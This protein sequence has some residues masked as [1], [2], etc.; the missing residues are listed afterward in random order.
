M[1]AFHQQERKEVR[2][3]RTLNEIIID[4]KEGKKVE[5][6]E[7]RLG[8][9]VFCNLLFFA[10][11]D[12]QHLLGENKLVR[13]IVETEYEGQPGRMG[14]RHITAL[15]K[16]PEEWLGNHHPDHPDQKRFMEIGNK[17]LDKVIK[18]QEREAEKDYSKFF[19][20]GNDCDCCGNQYICGK[21]GDA[22]GCKCIDEGKECNFI[23]TVEE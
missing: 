16:S 4:I 6:E 15:H 8:C 17:I 13:K 22:L 18:Q 21:D 9:L 11:G 12:I 1:R 19:N 10:E 2:T 7:A 3:V 5:Y 14:K 20:K 23:E